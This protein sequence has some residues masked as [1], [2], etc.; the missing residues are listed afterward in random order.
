MPIIIQTRGA[1]FNGDPAQ[2]IAGDWRAARRD[3]HPAKTV[4][5]SA[6]IEALRLV[7]DRC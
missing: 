4:D 1:R 5:T 3:A 6:L 7:C 2:A